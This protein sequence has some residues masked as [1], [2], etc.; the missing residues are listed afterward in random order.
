MYSM[1]LTISLWQRLDEW[2]K[3]LFIKLNSKWTNSF[4]DAVLPYFRD[5]VFWAPIYLFLLVFIAI[6]YGKK[7]LWWSLIFICTIAITD[8]IGARVF[9]V[10]FHRLRP[11]QDPEFSF[12]V[13]LL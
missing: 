9:K 6:N 2:D 7:G 13:R 3:W 4:F 1:A 8:M 10:A 12:H 11:C 5:P